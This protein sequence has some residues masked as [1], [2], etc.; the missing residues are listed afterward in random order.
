MFKRSTVALSLVAL[1]AG[2]G[3]VIAPHAFAQ[4]TQAPAPHARGMGR[5]QQK[6][7]LTDDQVKSIDDWVAGGAKQAGDTCDVG[8]LTSNGGCDHGNNTFTYTDQ[9]TGGVSHTYWVTAVYG[10]G[11]TSPYAPATLAESSEV[12]ALP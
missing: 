2:T 4:T 6:L 11:A 8:D 5:L 12:Q 7:G 3:A 1:L 9:S 10:S